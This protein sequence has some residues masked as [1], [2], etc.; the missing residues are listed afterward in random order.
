MP[1]QLSKLRPDRDLQCYFQEPSAVAALSGTSPSGFTVSGCWRQQFDWVVVE[2]N[3]D[4]VFEHPAL[5]NLPDGDLSGLHLSYEET[6]TNCIPLDSTTYDS[7]SWS[8][9]RIWEESN[10]TENFH[11]VPLNDDA[12]TDERIPRGF[13]P[14]NVQDIGGNLYVAFAEQDSQK[15]DE[16][17][18]AGL[19]YVDVF[20]PTGTL[21]RRL[22][23]GWWFNAPWGI[24]QASGDFGAYSHDILIG[25]FGSGQILAFDPVTGRYK[26]NLLNASGAPIAIDGLWGLSFGSG[27]G[28]GAANALYFAAGSDGEQ[29]GLFGTITAV[30]NVLG[31][32]R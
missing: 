1:D 2:W 12:F 26:G 7:I 23:S 32:D 24:A 11:R 18:G 5:R 27:T 10:N 21:L 22:Q 6:R 15:H 3:R 25:Q 29:H 14:F 28:S 17:D 16:V 30:E 19:G 4:N 31:G 13:A 20:S 8:Y 9:L